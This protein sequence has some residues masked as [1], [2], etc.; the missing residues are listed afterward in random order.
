MIGAAFGALAIAFA[1][2]GARQA[3]APAQPVF[4]TSVEVQVTSVSVDQLP[5]SVF[6]VLDTSASVSGERL[7]HLV[8]AGRGLVGALKAGDRAA[9]VTFSQA[10]RV[11]VPLTADLPR[12]ADAVSALQGASATSLRDAIHLALQLRGED[13]SRPVVLVFTDGRDTASWLSEAETIE[14]ARRSGVVIEA[15]DVSDGADAPFLNRLTDVAGGR[16]WSATSEGNLR[17]LFTKALEEMRA[18]YLLTFSPQGVAGEGWHELKVK[19]KGARGDVVAR[20]GYF[21]AAPRP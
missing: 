18:R 2:A 12:V 13:H 4:R 10:V 19:L 6:M 16:M 3:P 14:S 7:Q 8:D 5:L 9:L 20:P 15:V 17:A 1:A 21:R 11:R